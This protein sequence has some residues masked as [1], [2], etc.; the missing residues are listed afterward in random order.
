MRRLL[1][2]TLMLALT[3]CGEKQAD[4]DRPAFKAPPLPDFTTYK[5]VQEKK[6][7]FFDYLLPLITEANQRVL[8]Q[9]A[10]AEKWARDEEL[11]EKELQRL[12]RM[13]ENY[14]VKADDK[15]GQKEILLNR[16]NIIPPSL[17]LAQAA[18]EYAWGT[19][20]FATEGNN[21]FGQWCFSKGCGLVPSSRND[22]AVHEVR[23]FRSPMESVESY[24]QNLNRHAKYRQLR[25]IRHRLQEENQIISGPALA[26]GLIGYSERG[27]AYVDEIRHM[28][29]Y[30]GL[31]QYDQP[32]AAAPA[33][34]ESDA[35]Q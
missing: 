35:E 14:R 27:Q 29:E 4:S 28:I 33:T 32:D 30:N 21:L 26:A 17:V 10:L 1:T 23:K 8:E 12:T 18:N 31:Q 9:R 19:S 20:R 7:A 13:M 24:I 5:D 34:G 25:L 6:Q 15:A 11:T 2:V 22:G 16:V 3:A